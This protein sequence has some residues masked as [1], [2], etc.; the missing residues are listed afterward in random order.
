LER[1]YPELP[2]APAD[3]WREGIKAVAERI[4][5]MTDAELNSLGGSHI[6]LRNLVADRMALHGCDDLG[7]GGGNRVL[8]INWK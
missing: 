7:C 8:D 6:S 5:A 1:I 3:S 2:D 4:N